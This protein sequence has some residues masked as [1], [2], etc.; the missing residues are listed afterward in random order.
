MS[1]NCHW[2]AFETAANIRRRAVSAAEVTQAPL[3][4]MAAIDPN[5]NALPVPVFEATDAAHALD[6]KGPSQ[7]DGPLWGVSVIT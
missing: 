3:A 1:D 2:S 4:R 6:V 7:N 5:L